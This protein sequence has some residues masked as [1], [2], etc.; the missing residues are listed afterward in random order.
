M[1]PLRFSSRRIFHPRKNFWKIGG[2]AWI[3][4]LCLALQACAAFTAAVPLEAVFSGASLGIKVTELQKEIQ[5]ADVQE[6]FNLPFDKTWDVTLRAMRNLRLKIT[7]ADTT[8]EKDGGVIEAQAEKIEIKVA[9]ARVME[10]ITEIGIWA[11]HDKALA[12]LIVKRIKKE[13][14][15]QD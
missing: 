3:G 11:G 8:S 13:G 14:K 12:D 10:N 1:R 4:G 2:W 5:K 15:I 6:A 7:K 9:A